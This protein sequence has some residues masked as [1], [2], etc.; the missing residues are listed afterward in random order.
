MMTNKQTFVRY[1][2]VGEANVYTLGDI[3]KHRV[4]STKLPMAG[5]QS[6]DALIATGGTTTRL[7]GTFQ[8]VEKVFLVGVGGAV[9]HYTDFNKH[10]RLED[11]VLSAPTHDARFVY[12][13]FEREPLPGA[14]SGKYRFETKNWC[15]EDLCLQQIAESLT[16]NQFSDGP[17]P[18]W[19]SSYE[20][21]L[22]NLSECGGGG[23]ESVDNE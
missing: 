7:L 1:A 3:G 14:E 18:A 15:P 4:V 16:L 8:G 20:K 21:A 10:V 13:Y 6:R 9:P 23:G 22:A 17:P 12:Q 2:T 11:V 5:G 19:M